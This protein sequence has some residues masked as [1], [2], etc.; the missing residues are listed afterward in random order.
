MNPNKK[1]LAFVLLI[2]LIIQ[3]VLASPAYAAGT[4]GTGTP[5]SCNEGALDAA[6]LG[7]GAISFDCGSG[8]VTIDVTGAKTI[9]SDT[10][11]NG[12]GLIT[13][14][15]NGSVRLFFINSPVTL[16]LSDLTIS[17]GFV[18]G[19][20][21]GALFINSGAT[22]NIINSTF[23][24][25]QV[26]SGDGGAAYVSGGTLNVTNSTFTNNSVGG[27]N[28]GALFINSGA[29]VNILNS[30]F[31][32]N[33][34]M[35]GYGGATYV[36]G[37]TL[38]ITNST[39][40]NNDADVESIGD[41]A[42]GGGAIQNND[43]T[44]TIAGSTFNGNSV[45]SHSADGGAIYNGDFD[46]GA[47]IP[48][49]IPDVLNITNSTFSNNL[50]TNN[51]VNPTSGTSGGA[52]RSASTLTIIQSTF[53][54]NDSGITESESEAGAVTITHGT[55]TLTN[56]I[57]AD[58]SAA[59][60]AVR[61]TT[62]SVNSTGNLIETNH[63]GGFGCGTP[64]VS[65]D[66]KLIVLHDNGGPTQT[67][68]L[69]TGSPAI[70][71]LGSCV[72]GTDQRGVI[73][74]QPSAGNCDIGAYELDSL[75]PTVTNVTSPTANGTYITG[76]T[77]TINMAF[78]EVVN[79]TGTPQLI[80]ETGTTDRA[81]NY[82]SGSG[83]DTLTFTYTVQAGDASADLD[84]VSVNPLTLNGGT[85]QDKALN[86][87]GLTLA[88]PGTAG[89]LGF[90]QAIVI[91]AVAPSVTSFTRQ[92]PA[93]SSTDADTLVFRALFSEAVANV[94]LDDF[95][96]NGTTTAT[97]TNV[98][99][100]N[101]STYDVTVAG[102][103][104]AGF[105]GVVGLDLKGTQNITDL[106]GNALPTTEPSTDETYT[107]DNAVP[108]VSTIVRVD[109]NFTNASSVNFTVTFTESVTGVDAGDFALHTLGIAGSSI[110]NV[111]GSGATYTVTVN[112]GFGNGTI[113]L[114]LVDN[115]S[116]QDVIT[117]PLGGAGVGNGSFTGGEVYTV[118]K[119]ADT[120]G[121]FR[122]VN[123]LLYL[124]NKNETGFADAALNYGLPGD[125][126]VVGDWDGN[127]TVT[128]GIYRSGSFYLRNSNTLGFAEII[129]PFGQL[130]DQPIAGDWDGD[131]VDTIGIY[132][133]GNGQFLLRNSNSEGPADANFFLGN[134]GDVGI[135]GDWNGDGKDSTGVFR[136]SNGVI[137]LKDT[138]DTGFA[139]YALNYGLPGDKPVT[140]DW[141]NNGTDTIGIYRT[142][143][144][145]LRNENTNGFA[146][147]IF[148]LGNPGDIPIAGNWDGLP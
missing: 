71:F 99:T 134:V 112:T 146:E 18:S 16:E 27:G 3:A 127:G 47:G 136:P 138:N 119:G 34:T 29:T 75:A 21:G 24:G 128:I 7:G 54:G 57:F 94:S 90:N 106:P 107:V 116:I 125:Y 148:G 43:G 132:R 51:S 103:N 79:V 129:F 30:T 5:I 115:D 137:F 15:S 140:G 85:I 20:N 130:G 2:I 109:P 96:V 45:I 139:D 19:G 64:A 13:L 69:D 8:P 53:S 28:G 49:G 14:R 17:N 111:T 89:S 114:D 55:A 25:N 126:P 12:A 65:A 1:P 135:A 41:L 38:N 82:S 78:N 113:R 52:I 86:D 74:P 97:V 35:G 141:D 58:S 72:V 122:P 124:K 80:L 6:L 10:Q 11:I 44:V 117:V 62:T 87:A 83:T 60:C 23:S 92:T 76:N 50:L 88:N 66:P 121:V 9:S 93:I 142:G 100:I 37:G 105:N 61:A 104:L 143:S 98:A 70:D 39:F 40:S 22:V 59:D 26:L 42:L 133:P 32:S 56:N 95:V 46:G 33:Q 36:N 77:I 144:F 102:G 110:T 108:G 101:S 147:I 84:Y 145:Y 81:A 4:V 68:A 118:N 120:T 63:G 123:G 91:D 67:M 73:R 131:G 31:S 48:D